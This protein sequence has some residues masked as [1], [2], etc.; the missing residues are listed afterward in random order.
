MRA[1]G[2]GEPTG[3]LRQPR[4]RPLLP[5]W[6]R[7]AGRPGGL[8]SSRCRHGHFAQDDRGIG[9]L[10]AEASPRVAAFPLLTLGEGVATG[11]GSGGPRSGSLTCGAQAEFVHEEVS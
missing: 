2:W 10:P 5:R 1:G 7:Q 6:A 4:S 3:V 9:L 8:S 11:A